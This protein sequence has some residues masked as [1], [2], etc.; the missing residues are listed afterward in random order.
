MSSGS[1]QRLEK[2]FPA[3]VKVMFDATSQKI[4]V[5]RVIVASQGDGIGCYAVTFWIMNSLEGERAIF[6]MYNHLTLFKPYTPLTTL[7]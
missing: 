6:Y 2:Q 5:V 3:Q 7:Q 4:V 1:L